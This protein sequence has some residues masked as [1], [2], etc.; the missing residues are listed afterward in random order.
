MRLRTIAGF[1]LLAAL[2]A[3]GACSSS[4]GGTNTPTVCT[5]GDTRACLGP[6]ACVGAQA[7]ALDGA[8]WGACQCAGT[9][10]AIDTSIAD[11]AAGAD[12]AAADTGSDSGGTESNAEAA[13]DSTIAEIGADADAGAA[14]AGAADAVVDSSAA[15]SVADANS[16]A[17]DSTASDTGLT[18]I[19]EGGVACGAAICTGTAV[20]CASGGADGGA[21]SFTCASSCAGP[22]I[23]CTSPDNCGQNPCCTQIVRASTA[24][25]EMLCTKDPAECVPSINI[26]THSAQTRLCRNDADCTSG[27]A[28]T[29]L[30]KC[31]S[32]TYQGNS[33][34]GCF[35]PTY[36]PFASQVGA[37]IVCP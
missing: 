12:S 30:S 35:E 3:A 15:D 7:C 37:T 36:A 24:P 26:T 23:A 10:A 2:A 4:S 5:P 27:G 16:D 8:S 9:D 17:V 33:F 22:T 29:T 21:V 25:Q 34:K 14:D 6:G 32:I 18:S 13:I 1:V 19:H 11:T 28:T 31:C 20:C